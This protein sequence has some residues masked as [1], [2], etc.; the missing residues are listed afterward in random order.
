MSLEIRYLKSRPVCKVTFRL[1]AEAAP[2]AKTVHL[3]GEFNG[4]STKKCPMTRLKDGAFKIALDLE[5]GRAYRFRYLIDGKNWENDWEAH[6]YEPD[7]VV[8]VDNSV[9]EI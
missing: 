7:P 3:V 1:P 5:T 9:V 4:W 6:R 8:G 2:D